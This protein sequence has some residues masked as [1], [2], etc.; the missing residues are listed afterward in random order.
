M[1]NEAFQVKREFLYG[2][3]LAALLG[4]AFVACGDGDIT[5]FGT[6][7]NDSA[8]LNDTSYYRGNLS[9]A[10]AACEAD[11]VCAAKMEGTS[12][13]EPSSSGAEIVE[14]DPNPAE[15]SSSSGTS[16]NSAV[17][18]SSISII[19][20]TSSASEVGSSSSAEQGPTTLTGTC[21]PKTSPI[22]KGE[23]AVWVFSMTS[24]GMDAITAR[25]NA[26]FDWTLT[27]SAEG[28][29]S[30]KGSEGGTSATATYKA[31]GSYAASLSIDGGAAIQCSALQVNGAAIT[32]CE[33]TSDVSTVDVADGAQTVTWKV[34][35]CQSE[36][37]EITGY[38][39]TDATA[40]NGTASEA[41]ATLS[42][43]GDKAAPTVSVSNNDNTVQSFTCPAVTATN[44]AA[45]EYEIGKE[46]IE[47]PSGS[48]GTVTIAGTLIINTG[49]SES[50]RSFEIVV[51]SDTHTVEV[52]ARDGKYYEALGPVEVGQQVCVTAADGTSILN[53][54]VER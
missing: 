30:A 27:G 46:Y 47:I 8:L 4:G 49:W 6:A 21:A 43:K 34:S 44:S 26:T 2:I 10:M 5:T 16:S 14:P 51:G 1:Q 38:T 28:S 22:N 42:K 37:A 50:A 29:F 35:G 12:Y 20:P 15:N 11:P 33:C 23:S 52:N 48:C 17:S 39:W 41:T 40:S 19:A 53:L 54:K 13:A 7:N 25:N 36:G 24:S 32:G 18:S 3:S 9:S 45:P 31:S